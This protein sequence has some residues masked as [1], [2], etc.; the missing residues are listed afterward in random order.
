M[1]RILIADPSESFCAAL[2]RRLP[3]YEIH[4]CHTGNDAIAL[5][6]T[7]SPDILVINL[8]LPRTDGLQVL[9]Q[10]RNRV[11]TIALTPI[12]TQ[13]VCDTAAAHG[14]DL[15]VA[16]PCSPDY[17]AEEIHRRLNE[18]APSLED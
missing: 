18:K 10:L 2:A 9:R 16:I 8:C 3:G 4:T 7:F 12:L 6:A 11:P 1:D 13:A 17:L 5:L 15:L 14:V